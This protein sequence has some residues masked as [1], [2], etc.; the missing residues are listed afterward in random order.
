MVEEKG[1]GK[2]KAGA[3]RW[4][5]RGDEGGKGGGERGRDEGE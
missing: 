4:R 2:P 5:T 3:E 1:T